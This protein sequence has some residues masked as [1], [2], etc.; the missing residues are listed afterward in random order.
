MA[1]DAVE[2]EAQ[3]ATDGFYAALRALFTGDVGPMFEL[4]SHADDTLYLGP[5]GGIHAGW[6][7]IRAD[8]EAQAA[9]KLGGD[10]QHDMVFVT[11]TDD[12]AVTTCNGVGHN[13]GPDGTRLDVR[14]RG[15][16][17]FRR[18]NGALKLINFHSDLLPY[19]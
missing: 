11:A 7:A 13:V 6:P 2:T 14:L 10:I 9:L 1:N 8:W 3:R 15:T 12:L 19:L 17:V 16:H 5:D 18:E 4:W